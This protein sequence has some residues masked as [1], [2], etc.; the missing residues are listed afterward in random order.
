MRAF[1]AA[2]TGK[3]PFNKKMPRCGQKAFVSGI[4]NNM[5]EIHGNTAGL[6]SRTVEELKGLY[7]FKLSP[8]EFASEDMLF[9]M[10]RLTEV[11]GKEISVFLSRG[12]RVLDVS[13]GTDKSVKL[14]YMRVRRGS[15]GVSGIRAIHTHPGGSP[16][17]SNVDIGSL[18]SSRFDAMAA[19]SVKD[20][21]AAA[22]C[23]GFIGETLDQAKVTGP[24]RPG[25]IPQQAL[26]YEIAAATERTQNLVRMHET[27]DAPERAV[28]VGL[29][30]L[31][32]S[33]EELAR[34]AE[35]AG[36][37][38]VGSVTQNRDRDRAYY[39]G[40]GKAQELSLQMSALDA[41]IAIM[42][43]ELSPLETRNL[44]ET[45]GV[46]VVDRTMLIL[47]IFAAH[48][49]T[50]EG[51]LQVELAQLQYTLPRLAGEGVS[52]S[53]LGGGIG[54]RGPGEKKIEI[55]RRRIRRRIFELQQEIDKV[56]EQR[57][58]RRTARRENDVKE[59]A[60]VGYTN[61]GKSSLLNAL[62]NAGVRAEDKLFATLDPVTRRVVLPDVG[63]TVFTDTVGF[64]EKLP[65][66]LVSAFRST[67]EEVTRADLLLLVTDASSPN[68]EGQM[69]V[70][71]ELLSSLHANETPKILVMN[72]ADRL[73]QVPAAGQD[74][75]YI[76]A[77]TGEGLRTLLSLVAE[78]LAPQLMTYCG[79]LGYD[80]GDLLALVNR[81]GK[82]VA[83]DYR[84]D[85][86]HVEATLPVETIKKLKS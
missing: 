74:T 63:E 76:S 85:G 5:N 39:I 41:D 18:I 6:R 81:D 15:A 64:I 17:L 66:D 38:V 53:R 28:L 36:A 69:E 86:V 26:M 48:A 68:A 30:A 57:E 11:T 22:M 61:T 83:M 51:R 73:A 40:K 59:V 49:R 20:G 24:F 21:K 55:D 60:L 2:R 13:V 32:Q 67:L 50:R 43:D 34:L 54:T 62:T 75:V 27:E 4:I 31:Q 71:R 65:H 44:E 9:E 25:R 37:E 52:L 82:D 84:P 46:K 80:R 35:T 47:D 12:G 77:K 8:Q 42:N 7:E 29:N 78:K 45:L 79:T 10:A 70:V 14:P 23:V 1:F 3:R 58:L 72:K 33:M 19:V 16:M 56:A